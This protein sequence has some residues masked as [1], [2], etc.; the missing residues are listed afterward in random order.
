MARIRNILREGLEGLLATSEVILFIYTSQHDDAKKIYS[1]SSVRNS[2]DPEKTQYLQTVSFK[3][4]RNKNAS[5]KIQ[6]KGSLW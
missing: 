1:N 6:E 3:L 5:R 4:G 2:R